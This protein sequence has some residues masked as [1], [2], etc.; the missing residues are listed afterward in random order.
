MNTSNK[1]LIVLGDS[2]VGKTSLLTKLVKNKIDL[3]YKE[4]Y[5]CDFT[6]YEL[7][8]YDQLINLNIWD[9]YGDEDTLTII[10]SKLYKQSNCFIVMCSYRS[11]SS[12]YNIKKWV[13]HISNMIGENTQS[14]SIPI[15]VII[16]QADIKE[17]QFTKEEAFSFLKKHNLFYVFESS[18]YGNTKKLIYD[19]SEFLLGKSN[20]RRKS[21]VLSDNRLSIKQ[22]DKEHEEEEVSFFGKETEFATKLNEKCDLSIEQIKLSTLINLE[23]SKKLTSSKRE[24]DKKK[25]STCCF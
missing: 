21:S 18:I 11:K 3:N 9:T 15:I 17:K 7:T 10:P 19:V 12:L 2:F 25:K 22:K 13:D 4:T 23:S 14:P 24:I 20:L 1:L 16:N 5:G 6:N 8:I